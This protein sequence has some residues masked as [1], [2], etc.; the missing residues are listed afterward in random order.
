MPD[1]INHIAYI[2]GTDAANRSMREKGNTRWTQEE[3]DIACAEF[4]RILDPYCR[5]EV[6][7]VSRLPGYMAHSAWEGGIICR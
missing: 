3:Y 1:T 6:Q 4:H 5:K 2:A 7:R